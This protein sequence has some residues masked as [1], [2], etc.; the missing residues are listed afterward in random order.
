MGSN[1]SQSRPKVSGI[2]LSVSHAVTCSVCVTAVWARKCCSPIQFDEKYA[3]QRSS[4]ITSVTAGLVR[5]PEV[6]PKPV[7]LAFTLY[8]V[9]PSMLSIMKLTVLDEYGVNA[10]VKD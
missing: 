7:L 10:E 4:E 3:A 5:R 1:V 9:L 2:F 6:E 8:Y